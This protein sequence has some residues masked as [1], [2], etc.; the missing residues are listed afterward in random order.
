MVEQHFREKHTV[1]EYADLLY[2]SPK[3]LSNVFKKVGSK[4]PL[5]LIHNRKM[6]EAR[7]LLHHTDA[8]ISD[9]GYDLGF[10]DIQ[11]F[12]RFF[13]KN[14]GISPSEFKEKGTK[15]KIAN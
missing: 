8:N 4:T 9:I 7:R 3:T 15:G 12:S 14:E 13:K 10:N 5:E 1:G 6:I 2:K 11:A